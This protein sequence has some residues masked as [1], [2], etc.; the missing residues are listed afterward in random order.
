M[1]TRSLGFSAAEALLYLC[2]SR[3]GRDRLSK[4]LIGLTLVAGIVV[5]FARFLVG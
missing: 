1:S 2:A 5:G 3:C 4:A